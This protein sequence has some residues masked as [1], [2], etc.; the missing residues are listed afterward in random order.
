[1]RSR[2]RTHG[3]GRSAQGKRPR[4][5]SFIDA[6]AFDADDSGLEEE[7][8]DDGDGDVSDLIDDDDEESDHESDNNY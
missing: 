7:D 3:G 5:C 1:M 2:T 6:S 4:T 8:E